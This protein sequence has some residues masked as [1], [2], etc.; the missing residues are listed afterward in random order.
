MNE[1]KKEF[2]LLKPKLDIVFQSLFN[3]ANERITKNFVESLLN[4]KIKK[5]QINETKELYREL[6]EDKLGILDLELDINNKEKID[7][8]I[9]LVTPKNFASRLLYYFAKLYASTV[10][11]KQ[12]YVNAKRVVIVAIIDDKFEVTKEIKEME[13]KWKLM[14]R[15]HPEL[16]LTN[17]L[18]IDIIELK[19][20]K[21]NYLKN[22][23]DVKSQWLLFLEDIESKE[24]GE[25]VKEN[26]EIKEAVIKVHQMSKDEELQRKADLREK[27]IM[28]QK[29]MYSSG[30]EDG[31]EIRAKTGNRKGAKGRKNKNSKKTVETECSNRKNS[32]SNRV[33]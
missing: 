5:I 13:T 3:Q 33:N 7:V 30:K 22:K 27:Y 19:K 29:A 17:K 21:E 26:E 24:V 10:K 18:E 32:R 25:I 28:D 8:E 4:E 20:V 14:C 15:E 2:R 12:D 9:Q 1:E 23:K 6:P 16:E 31:M 11:I